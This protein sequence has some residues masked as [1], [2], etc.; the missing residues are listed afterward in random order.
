MVEHKLTASQWGTWK[1]RFRDGFW[2]LTGGL[3]DQKTKTPQAGMAIASKKGIT[4]LETQIKSANFQK[5]YDD[6]R[7]CKCLLDVGW[8]VNFHIYVLY[9]KA[10]GTKAAKNYNGMAGRL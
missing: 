3:A 7:A 5:A 8:D 2:K 1:E 4:H 10:G 6:G 9:M